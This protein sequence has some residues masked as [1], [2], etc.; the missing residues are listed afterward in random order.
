MSQ[1]FFTDQNGRRW[2][3][4]W[5][6]PSQGYYASRENDKPDPCT[7]C[8]DVTWEDCKICAG[9]DWQEF[10]V[11]IGF[12]RG[13]SIIELDAMT[14][15]SGFKMT[16]E[17]LDQLEEDRA[18]QERPLTPLQKNIRAMFEQSASNKV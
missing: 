10:D 17:Q 3:C 9:R 7:I 11:L 18:R 2:M 4:G 16:P 14:A 13:V 1:L 8:T 6:N 15:M 12:G 5:D